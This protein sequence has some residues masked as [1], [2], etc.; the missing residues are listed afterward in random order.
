MNSL[1]VAITGASGARYGIRILEMLKRGEIESHLIVS[2]AGATTIEIETGYSYEQVAALADNHHPVENIGAP[3]AS[4]SFPVDGMIITPCSIKTLSAVANSYTDNLITRAA[5]VQLKED[6]PLL[7]MVR[8]TPLHL[9]HLKLM[10][11]AAEIGVII[12]PPIP[13]WY[14]QPAS[15]DD[16]VD[17]TLER[18]LQ[19]L[20]IGSDSAYVWQG[21]PS[22]K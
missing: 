5:D 17:N 7:L 9:G 12:M 2:D 18:A 8:E 4:G 22:E 3:I 6:R 13:S 1:I 11:R 20:G 10:T 16:L 15:L 14:Q 21:K 19:R